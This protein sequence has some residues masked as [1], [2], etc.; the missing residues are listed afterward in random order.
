VRDFEIDGK[1]LKSMNW[2]AGAVAERMMMPGENEGDV[3]GRESHTRILMACP[4][5]CESP[6][7]NIV[8]ESLLLY[9]MI[10]QPNILFYG[11]QYFSFDGRL[12]EEIYSQRGSTPWSICRGLL[13]SEV[14]TP[15]ASSSDKNFVRYLQG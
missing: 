15:S 13:P 11:H 7:S 9:G 1:W 14:D 12:P 3:K 2:D 6:K 10:S 8:H 4:V 5:T